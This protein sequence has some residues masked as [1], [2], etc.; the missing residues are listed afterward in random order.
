MSI[1]NILIIFFCINTI[2]SCRE[3]NNVKIHEG[4]SEYFIEL[5]KSDYVKPLKSLQN[6]DYEKYSIA[7]NYIPHTENI[8]DYYFGIDLIINSD[9]S[10]K[11]LRLKE[12]NSSEYENIIIK[13]ID[14]IIWHYESML[15]KNFN[16]SSDYGDITGKSYT[17][18]F[19]SNN[20]FVKRTFWR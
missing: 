19:D 14:Y 20:K 17:L 10:E 12:F 15:E 1:K 11:S 7:I 5:I 18:T 3:K 16:E 6:M 9:N 13:K 2:I 8:E 4:I